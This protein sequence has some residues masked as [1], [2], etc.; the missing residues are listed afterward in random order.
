[1]LFILVII[2]IFDKMK[3]TRTLHAQ[4]AD[5][6]GK[7]FEFLFDKEVS[8]LHVNVCGNWQNNSSGDYI[9][10]HMS[11]VETSVMNPGAPGVFLWD[12]LLTTISTNGGFTTKNLLSYDLHGRRVKELYVRVANSSG[13][14]MQ[15]V[16]DLMYEK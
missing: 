6:A 15:V 9:A 13:A 5:S 7:V 11:D 8:L 2:K 4:I 10:V 16:I 1:M 12:K 14:T 3:L